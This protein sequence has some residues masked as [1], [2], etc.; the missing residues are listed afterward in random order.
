MEGPGLV[1]GG[2]AAPSGY[3]AQIDIPETVFESL[4]KV[5]EIKNKTTTKKTDKNAL[6]GSGEG[7]ALKVIKKHKNTK[8]EK[9]K[10][11]IF[12]VHKK[13]PLNAACYDRCR[14][15]RLI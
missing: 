15:S 1:E 11:F 9:T 5:W 3:K 8:D 6:L 10:K 7:E 2:G 4:Y 13:K 12:L 14:L